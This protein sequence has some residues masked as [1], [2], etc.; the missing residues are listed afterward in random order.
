VHV[1]VDELTQII[2]RGNS[3]TVAG[4]VAVPAEQVAECE[5]ILRAECVGVHG[6]F[7]GDYGAWGTLQSRGVLQC[8]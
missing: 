6:P 4:R 8:V 5:E 2:R 1:N 3:G 7:V